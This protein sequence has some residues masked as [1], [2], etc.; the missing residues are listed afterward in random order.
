MSSLTDSFSSTDNDNKLSTVVGSEVLEHNSGDF[1]GETF[2]ARSAGV[3]SGNSSG[4]TYLVYNK[5][6]GPSYQEPKNLPQ[7]HP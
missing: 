4:E 5:G 3:D 2:D 6:E 1:S 7:H